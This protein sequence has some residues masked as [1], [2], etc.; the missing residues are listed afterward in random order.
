MRTRFSTLA[1]TAAALGTASIA[2][3]Q[4]LELSY[5]Q[6]DIGGG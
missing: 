2:S 5:S 3:A 6:T 1:L 4:G